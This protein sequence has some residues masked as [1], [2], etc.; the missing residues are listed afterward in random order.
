MMWKG[1]ILDTSTNPLNPGEKRE[2]LGADEAY[3]TT[4]TGDCEAWSYYLDTVLNANDFMPR[5]SIFK[6]SLGTVI[7]RVKFFEGTEMEV[8][9]R[10]DGIRGRIDAYDP[11]RKIIY[12]IKTTENDKVKY[13]EI[14]PHHNNQALLYWAG[15]YLSEDVLARQAFVTYIVI[16]REQIVPL[17]VKLSKKTPSVAAL[18]DVWQKALEKKDL[19]VACRKAKMVP[20]CAWGTWNC[21][22]CGFNRKC[23]MDAPYFMD[24]PYYKNKQDETKDVFEET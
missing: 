7:H 3:V 11:V 19:L 5:K 16:P 23:V 9:M 24:H 17:E 12:E 1:L 8:R 6:T 2:P 4:L 10:H 18:E 14:N 13:P 22:Y 20:P 15:K 21:D